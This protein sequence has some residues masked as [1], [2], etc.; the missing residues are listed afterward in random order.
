MLNLRMH[1]KVTQATFN[2]SYTESEMNAI[3]AGFVE[4]TDVNL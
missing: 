3:A 1:H 4:I 2:P